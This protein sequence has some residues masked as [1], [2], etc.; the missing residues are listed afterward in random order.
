MIFF[1]I[2]VFMYIQFFTL[3]VFCQ[4]IEGQ[5]IDTL[6]HP[7]EFVNVVFLSLKDTT[8]I[9][10]A[11][12]D[13]D[14][15]FSIDSKGKQGFLRFSRI[16]YSTLEMNVDG[17][18]I[19]EA[20]LCENKNTLSEVV[21]KSNLP[22]TILKD[23]GMLTNIAGSFLEK[24]G[25]LEHVLSYIPNIIIIDGEVQ[26]LGRGVPDFYLN[27]HKVIDRMELKDLRSEDI[28][29]I[30][31]INNPGAR[32]GAAI[33]SVI[34][35]TTKTRK[36]NSWGVDFSSTSGINEEKRFS[37]TNVVAL[38]FHYKKIDIYSSLYC[39]YSKTEDDKQV[40]QF[41]YLDN[42]W[43]KN[44]N[45][46]QE[47]TNI[48]PYAKLA[49]S[50]QLND[51]TSLGVRAS[52]DRY[53]KNYGCG[54]MDAVVVK[55]SNISESSHS[56]YESPANSSSVTTNAY[57]VGK[58][59]NL[60]VDFN[61]DYYWYNKKEHM[62]NSEWI[63][64]NMN[65]TPSER[66]ETSRNSYCYQLASK[67]NLE[68]P[69]FGGR[70]SWGGEYS[71]N[72][73]KSE[74]DVHPV[75]LLNNE[76]STVKEKMYST[77]CDYNRHFGKVIILMGLRYE[78]MNFKYYNH[79]EYV[80]SQSKKFSDL[81]PSLSILFPIGESQMQINYASDINRP[82]YYQLRN[83]IQYDNR[84]T[85][86]SGNPY[87]LP[88]KNRNLGFNFTWS[89]IAF[90]AIYSHISDEIYSIV[91]PYDENMQISIMRPENMES[92]DKIQT[93]LSLSPSIG[94]WH[95]QLKAAISKQWF[96]M[97]NPNSKSLSNLIGTFHVNNTFDTKWFMAS[98]L[99]TV[100]TEG[101]VG[102]CFTYSYWNTDILLYKTLLKD[103]LTI[104]L[105]ANDVFGTANLRRVIYSGKQSCSNIKSYSSSS[106]MLTIRYT[107]NAKNDKYKGTGAG[108]QQ[109]K[110]L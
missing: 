48:N 71:D 82:S 62:Y 61:I 14:G 63:N 5:T 16:G 77:F 72:K 1:R 94:F 109:R 9:N 97:P 99:M 17:Q 13:V 52:Y 65:S 79:E 35:I 88:S 106:V 30:E 69:L 110:R 86:E 108:I 26:V 27:G 8:F 29:N 51:S 75:N 64:V 84:Y 23:E 22:K 66:I 49:I 57:Y 12:T 50:Y 60:T 103:R 73:R 10:G 87:L 25:N 101:N 95:P 67:I 42:N 55:D 2:V 18:K 36:E 32:Y 54:T 39:D 104:Q 6:G 80:P 78:N 11:G 90:S 47:Y 100:Q 68:I 15:K 20:V 33:K 92:Y 85:Y 107:F 91:K 43:E 45:I 74:Y 56:Y 34:R 53:A 93:N 83:G 58:I 28:K 44:N 31:V 21:I 7:L 4:N 46:I 70:F 81:F 102:N 38:N 89:F 41:T 37:T 24:A 105:Y 96:Y 59:G 76:R 40:Q 3:N 19:I 98:L